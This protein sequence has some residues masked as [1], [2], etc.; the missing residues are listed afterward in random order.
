MC[1]ALSK[2]ESD[3]N[4]TALRTAKTPLSFGSS[5]CSRVKGL[6]VDYCSTGT[7]TK[8]FL[9]SCM[10]SELVE[11]SNDNFWAVVRICNLRL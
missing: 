10:I 11:L 5:E 8:C 6:H 3:V 9:N 4:P 1:L 7:I 2:Q